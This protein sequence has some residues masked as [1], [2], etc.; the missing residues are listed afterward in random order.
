LTVQAIAARDF[1]L[2]QGVV[3]LGAVTAIALNLVADVLY[4][5][6]DPRIRMGGQA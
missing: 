3:L 1:M 5:I 6:I 4:S 2:V